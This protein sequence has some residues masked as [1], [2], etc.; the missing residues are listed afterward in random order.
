MSDKNCKL[1]I[2]GIPYAPT[3]ASK[4]DFTEK[5][6]YLARDYRCELEVSK[7]QPYFSFNDITMID[8][9]GFFGILVLFVN[10]V[11]L[12]IKKKGGKMK[13]FFK[14]ESLDKN[15]LKE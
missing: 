7:E 5:F 11:V 13:S 8:A 1:T 15:N 9:I 2:E 12:F 4:M 14:E 3:E 10:I 6:Y